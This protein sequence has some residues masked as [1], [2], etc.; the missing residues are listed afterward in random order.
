[1]KRSPIPALLL[2]VLVVTAGFATAQ[3]AAD[4]N[5]VYLHVRV[6]DNVRGRPVRG[7]SA[8]QFK[9][10]EDDKLQNIV[11]FSPNDDAPLAVGIL[12]DL[13]GDEKARI[14]EAVDTLTQTLSRQDQIFMAETGKT[15]L[16]DAVYQNINKLLQL[17]N[18]RRALVLI[19]DR[20]DPDGYVFSKVKELVRG[21]SIQ[22]YSIVTSQSGISSTDHRGDILRELSEISGGTS[23][24]PTSIFELRDISKKIAVELKNQYVIG[25]RPTNQA[26][27]GKWRKIKVTADVPDNKNK[28]QRLAGRTRSGYYAPESYSAKN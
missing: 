15:Q 1:M 23:Y 9:V 19:S 28:V 5:L 8:E 6:I 13:H 20:S 16:N 18:N 17:P 3:I 26:K 24:F 22:F 12:I 10:L 7:I 25:Y 14:K 4:P 2:A 11:Y 27:D 21:Q